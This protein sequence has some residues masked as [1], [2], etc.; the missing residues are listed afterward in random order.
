MAANDGQGHVNASGGTAL[1]AVGPGEEQLFDPGGDL[2]AA[3]GRARPALGVRAALAA[4]RAL[5]SLAGRVVPAQV[6][7]FDLSLASIRGASL[8]TVA[9]LGVADLLG[10]GP[11]GADELAGALGVDADALHRVLRSLVLDG[12]FT[13]EPGGRF[14]LTAQGRRLRTDHPQSM[15]AWIVYFHTR[16]NQAAWEELDDVVRTGVPAFPRRFGRSVWSWFDEHPDEGRLFASA[17]RR[18]TE[19]EAPEIVAA[20]PWPAR[21]VVCDLAGGSGTLLSHV[22]DRNPPLTGILVE[23]PLVLQEADVL[24]RHRGLRDRVALTAGDLFRGVTATADVYLLKNVLHDWD[25]DAC[26]HILRTVRSAVPDGATLVVIEL[27]QERNRAAYPASLT[28]L[29]MMVACDAGRERSAD[30]L[31]ALLRDAGFAPTRTYRTGTG[32]GLV[33]ATAGHAGSEGHG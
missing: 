21:G 12:V 24:F 11:K 29:Q 18:L 33:A 27:L 7:L 6:A 26:R 19:L 2:P 22:L 16:S 3:L 14:S 30:E 1:P 4:R 20:Y 15:R 25:D 17:M 13:V 10:D 9:R 8:A 31:R 5:L 32:T 28:D 23:A